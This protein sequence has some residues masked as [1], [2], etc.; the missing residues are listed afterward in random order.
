MCFGCPVTDAVF[1]FITTCGMA[2]DDY[3]LTVFVTSLVDCLLCWCLPQYLCCK[4]T[5]KISSLLVSIL[6]GDTLR[7]CKCLFPHQTLTQEFSIHWCFLTELLPWGLPSSYFLVPL[8][9]LLHLLVVFLQSCLLLKKSFLFSLKNFFFTYFYEN[10]FMGI[11]FI[12]WIII[13]FYHSLLVLMFKIS[14]VWP[15]GTTA[16]WILCPFDISVIVWALPS[17]M[18]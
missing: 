7:L 3:L 10:G 14:Q 17:F 2:H 18:T 15:V 11:Y 1:F 4:V 12:Q 5:I 13:C 9:F 16:S 6:C 8:T